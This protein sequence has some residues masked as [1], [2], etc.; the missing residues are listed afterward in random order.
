MCVPV[1]LLCGFMSHV[2]LASRHM[3]M[4][5]GVCFS[6]GAHVSA[7]VCI[8][9]L[10]HMSV[11]PVPLHARMCLWISTGHSFGHTYICLAT[12]IHASWVSEGLPQQSSS[13]QNHHTRESARNTSGASEHYVSQECPL[14]VGLWQSSVLSWFLLLSD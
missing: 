2:C 3:L 14:T 12:Y 10:E 13:G 9:S 6:V 1:P 7:H 11:Y 8:V 5:T 4:C